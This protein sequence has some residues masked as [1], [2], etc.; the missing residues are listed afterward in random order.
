MALAL[1]ISVQISPAPCSLHR[2]RKGRS[3]TPAIG[4]STRLFSSVTFPI[5]SFIPALCLFVFFVYDPKAFQS[6]PLIIDIDGLSLPGQYLSQA[7]GS[8]YLLIFHA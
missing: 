6:Q 1:T 3:V 4:A 5:L 7:S 2:R 8:H